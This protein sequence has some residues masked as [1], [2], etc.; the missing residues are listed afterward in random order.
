MFLQNQLE[1]YQWSY[2]QSSPMKLIGTQRYPVG[3]Q[4]AMHTPKPTQWLSGRS[5]VKKL[6]L[7]CLD[8]TEP[9]CID[10]I[11]GKVNVTAI[12]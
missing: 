2:S 11:V 6:L 9:T 7:F 3:L 10:N 1:S 5:E 4:D 8:M 12:L